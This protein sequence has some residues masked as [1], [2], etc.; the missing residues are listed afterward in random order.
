M[1][2]VG[3]DGDIVWRP[4]SDLM[5]A[6]QLRRFMSAHGIQ[7]L[8][9]LHRRAGDDPRW[10]WNAV[11]ADLGI[12]FFTP[13]HDVI[14][15]S[16]GLPW[17]RWCLGGG[18]NIVHN[19]L[20]KRMG[21][22]REHS[23]AVRW[24]GEDGDTTVLTY[25][26]L[27]C[28]VNRA[29]NGLTRLG[30]AKG[31]VIGLCMPMVPEIAMAFFAIVKIGAIVM[32]LFSGYGADAIATRLADAGA[33][34]LITADWGRRR[35]HAIAL[36][37][38]ADEAV[39]NIA[40]VRHVIVVSRHGEAVPMQAGRDLW[41][42]EMIER[43]STACET[44][45]T[46]ADEPFMLIYTSGTTGRP[47]GAVHSHCGFPIK[48]AQDLQHGFDM[49]GEDILFWV[50]DMGWMM[51][52]WELLGATILG[53]TIVL[54]DG[55][56]D[57]PTSDRL[58]SLVDEHRVSVLGVSPTLIRVLMH[59]D[60]GAV[61]R[62]DLSSLRILGSTGEP[63]NPDPWRWF[64]EKAGKSRLPIINYS[65]GTEI[66]GGILSGN[67]L[68]AMK[69]CAFSG[70]LPGIDAD[71]VDQRGQSVR[72]QVGELV[73]RKPW[74]GM[75]RGFWNDPERYL[76]TYWSRFPDVWVHGD[77]AAVGE[78]ED[79]LW[80]IFGRSDDTLKIA[81]K[82]V[83]PAEIES[84]LVAHPMVKEAAAI[85]APD[86]IK[87]EKLICFCV[88]S[89]DGQAGPALEQELK[90]RV[91]HAMGNALKPD[92][93]RFVHELPKTR[94]GKVM[95]RVIRALYAGQDPGDLSALDDVSRSHLR[96]FS[97]AGERL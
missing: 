62:H 57:Y 53:A 38:V 82:R 41:W 29:A 89:G 2:S 36:K 52:P 21:T 40:S 60:G 42:H 22:A 85:G 61:D 17:T 90:D 26:E 95:R 33:A 13:Y 51:G 19:C 20:D 75:T 49:H 10:F 70:P 87:G 1:T 23:P 80:Y 97:D 94:N 11:L 27:C 8:S 35:G 47:K 45:R 12:E 73:I 69:P 37:P 15:T 46:A 86:E 44:A 25:G 81:G 71:V 28:E 93:V 54:F 18:M 55:A 84:V 34:G 74:I 6:S 7:H 72:G 76:Q 4:T 50:T 63:W 5:K 39:R 3:F 56:I 77:W 67:V 58:W 16:H 65:G 78:G 88:L 83:G 59:A 68:T 48:A 91:K 9:E 24:T 14:D 66:S 43:E 30:F 32:P 64:F 92:A 96:E 79:G 31:D